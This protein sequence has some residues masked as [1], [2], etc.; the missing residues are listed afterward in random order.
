MTAMTM[1]APFWKRAVVNVLDFV[2]SFTASGHVVRL[3]YGNSAAGSTQAAAVV[4][5]VTYSANINVNGFGF[6]HTGTAAALVIALTVAYF[7]IGRYVAG[8][9]IWQRV[10][11]TRC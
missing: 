8:G 3:I 7:V 1:K 5:G 9:T 10:L 2:T 11:G 6:Q 4:N